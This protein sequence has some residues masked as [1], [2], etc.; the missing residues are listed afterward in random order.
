MRWF[1]KNRILVPFD[2]SD[3]SLHAIR[4][5]MALAENVEH[6]HVVHVLQDG[7]AWDAIDEALWRAPRR[8]EDVLKSIQEKLEIANIADVQVDVRIGDPATAIVAFAN[9]VDID[10]IV[11]PSHG[12]GGLER[13]LLGSVARGVVRHAKCPVLVL[14]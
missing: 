6:V 14:K 12:Y 9:E 3:Q 2:F 8:Q 4:V 10:L 7:H 13:M 11:I 1:K 5:G